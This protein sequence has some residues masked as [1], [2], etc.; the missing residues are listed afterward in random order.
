M[1][2]VNTTRMFPDVIGQENVKRKLGFYAQNYKANNRIPHLFYSAPKG[3][4]KTHLAN[5]MAR[6]LASREEEGKAKKY[7]TINCSELKSLS[8]FVNEF[9]IPKVVDQECTV[10][11]DECHM[12]PK[13]IANALLTILNPNKDRRTEYSYEDFDMEF[14]FCRQS[15]MMAT[16]EYDKVFEPLK[17]R[18]TEITLQEYTLDELG[19]I[20]I[21]NLN[22]YDF[23]DGVLEDIAAVSRGNARTATTLADDIKDNLDMLGTKTLTKDIWDYFKYAHNINP[24]GLY[25]REIGVLNVLNENHPTPVSVSFVCANVGDTLGTV[26]NYE[27]MLMKN[28]LMERENNCQRI[29]TKKG[30]DYID[31]LNKIV[32][33]NKEYE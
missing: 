10:F 24:L 23:E 1:K 30:R 27:R 7:M 6:L 5:A 15:F 8:K 26:Q 3:A 31:E 18:F 25:E 19:R 22:G 29:I 33:R 28:G 9:L 13:G 32:E 11:F 20:A 2:A 21:L 12:M 17:S 14:D 4:G 16:T